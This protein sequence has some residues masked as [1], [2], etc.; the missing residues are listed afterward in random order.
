MP[1][2]IPGLLYHTLLSVTNLKEAE[3]SIETV[4]VLGTHGTL[5]AAKVFA[6]TSL[7]K[8]LHFSHDDFDFYDQRDPG[9]PWTHGDNVFVFARTPSGKFLTVFVDTKPNKN[10]LEADSQGSIVL[11]GKVDQLYYVL[12]KC[13]DYHRSS[14]QQLESTELQD[15]YLNYADALD[16]ARMCLADDR[17]SLSKYHERENLKPAEEWPF[18]KDVHVHAASE[19]G[20]IFTVAVRTVSGAKQ[21]HAKSQAL[22]YQHEC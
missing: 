3:G 6:T 2:T 16:A 18:G 5:D 17:T 20:Q 11:P 15:C 21:E 22:V 12:R 8:Q 1:L 13:A 7:L 19:T 9:R 4:F 10:N 14:F